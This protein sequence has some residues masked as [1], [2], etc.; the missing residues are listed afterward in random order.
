[1]A[2]LSGRVGPYEVLGPLGAGGMGEVFR[3]LDTRL[4]RPVALKVLPAEFAADPDRL[5][6]FRREA[7]ALASMNHPNIATIHGLE[8]LPGGGLALVLEFVSGETLAARLERG[9]MGPADAVSV[10]SKIAEALEAAHEKGI[11]HRDLKPQNIMFG[12]QDRLKVLDFGL[13]RRERDQGDDGVLGTAGYLSPEQA[14]GTAQDARTDVFAF[15]CV[16]YECLA[17]G[18]AFPGDDLQLAGASALYLEPDWNALPAGLPPGLT[19]LLAR[20]LAKD[21]DLRPRDAS[22]LRAA[23]AAIGRAEV[24]APAPAR[25]V[26]R[27][28]E[29]R[30]SFVG[31]ARELEDLA[32]RLGSTRLLTLTGVG[33][34]GKTRLALRVAESVRGSF[35]AGVWF[36]DLAPLPDGARVADSVARALELALETGRDA[37]ETV[38]AA[39]GGGRVLLLVDNAE[40]V[41]APCAEVVE[42]LLAACPA[43]AVIATSRE[44]LALAGEDVAAIGTLELPPVRGRATAASLAR[45]DAATL[46]VE[47]ARAA[48]PGF[49]LD[50]AN[51]PAVAE[52]CRR[53]DGIPLALELAAARVKML[54]VEQVR[55]RLDDRFKLLTGGLRTALPRQQTLHATLQWSYDHLHA[56]EQDLLRR[57]AVFAGGW[58]LEQASAVCAPGEDEFELLDRLT[59]LA[60]K[61]LVV[62]EGRTDPTRYRFLES[63]RQFALEALE[64]TDEAAA[65]RERHFGAFLAVASR[66]EALG[67]GRA[68]EGEHLRRLDA[69]HEN[70]LAALAWRLRAAGEAAGALALATGIWRYWSSRGLFALARRS[71]EDA[72]ASAGDGAPAALRAHARTRAGGFALYLGD[73]EG[74]HPHLLEA[75]RLYGEMNDAKG[76][77]RSLSALATVAVYRADLPDARRRYAASLET[78]AAL[79]EKRG[80]ALAHQGLGYVATRLGEYAEARRELEAALES[81]RDIG[82]HRLTAH[83][84]ADLGSAWALAGGTEQATLLTSA[85]LGIAIEMDLRFEAVA[86]IEVAAYLLAHS[87]DPATAARL[88]GAADAARRALGSSLPPHEQAERRALDATI[89]A[90]LEE[91]AVVR[92]AASG[93]SLEVG[94]AAQASLEALA[95]FGDTKHE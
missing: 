17:G 19:E 87:G 18:R 68:D 84:L 62:V 8:S 91:E 93:A 53:L 82:D 67:A 74:A 66:F 70:L 20:C 31:R 54:S 6:R 63:V 34:C 43:L 14:M 49:A 36:V 90:S 60:D 85:A 27:L 73:H 40:H 81:A 65:V 48:N 41:L 46:F 89:L 2:T 25:G 69:D 35:P 80:V 95:V 78:Y 11:V 30:T 94:E 7:L 72:L 51:A 29:T 24:G 61:S 50:D 3:A 16:L 1:L 88:F 71:L 4:E 58:T 79:G 59:R 52:I 12:E 22:E 45:S 64:A 38:A 10:G 57:L 28:P 44:P 42:R 15:G 37:V 33:G 83:A 13:A 86:A 47:R 23:L 9:A 39:I 26:V 56:E 75:D 5:E 21:A 55:S 92:A 76:R 77:A 32:A